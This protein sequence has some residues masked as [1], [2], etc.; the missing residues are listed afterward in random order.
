MKRKKW[1]I[2]SLEH[3]AWWNP[4]GIGYCLQKARAGRFTLEKACEIVHE[5]N[6][7]IGDAPPAEA[8]ILD[9]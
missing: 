4:D 3:K 6:K 5:A 2:W 9:E 7:V 1:L 8:M